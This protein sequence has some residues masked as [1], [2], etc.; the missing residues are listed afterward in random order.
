MTLLIN[1]EF[2]KAKY[3]TRQGKMEKFIIEENMRYKT[4]RLVQK[5]YII[6][7][8]YM[9]SIPFIIVVDKQCFFFNF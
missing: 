2:Y 7:K 9:N 3:L 1:S 6:S 5:S 8:F 4:I